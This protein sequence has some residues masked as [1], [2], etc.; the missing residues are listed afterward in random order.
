[1]SRHERETKSAS[2]ATIAL[3]FAPMTT[4]TEAGATFDDGVLRSPSSV[5]TLRV[6]RTRGGRRSEDEFDRSET[7]ARG[8]AN[9]RRPA[10]P[11]LAPR[12]E[13]IIEA[14]RG[15]SA[16]AQR[17]REIERFELEEDRPNGT[18]SRSFS[19]RKVACG[20]GFEPATAE[21]GL[22]ALPL[23]YPQSGRV[24]T[25]RARRVFANPK[26][27]R[28]AESR[29]RRPNHREQGASADKQVRA[30][31]RSSSCGWRRSR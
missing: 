23:S 20:T 11:T 29:L 30:A 16:G 26:T 5:A 15:L 10:L 1:M 17:D 4:R 27:G 8:K 21:S 13:S 19:R 12:I 6:A 2:G 7:E 31:V 24:V 28:T 3:A 22:G 25:T 18:R 9:D 14:P